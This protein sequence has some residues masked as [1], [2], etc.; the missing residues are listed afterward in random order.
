[1]AEPG[2]LAVR[3]PRAH[4]TRKQVLA[5]R[6]MGATFDAI[7]K[8][9]GF[10]A[11]ASR[12]HYR[13]ALEAISPLEEAQERKAALAR[14]ESLR[15]TLNIKLAEVRGKDATPEN[16]LALERLV[17]ALLLCEHQIA[18]LL[19]LYGPK[20]LKVEDTG[21]FSLADITQITDTL[22]ARGE[23][24]RQE[25]NAARLAAMSKDALV[26]KTGTPMT[27]DDLEASRRA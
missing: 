26:E 16:A 23:R 7:G 4:K 14:I 9:L 6:L 12:K 25:R 2:K 17:S 19:G 3:R 8:Q 13:R 11:F 21:R 24:L 10:T 22:D 15:F 20:Q 18:M 1:M 5:L 27:I